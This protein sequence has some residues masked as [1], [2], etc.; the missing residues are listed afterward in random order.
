M[1]ETPDQQELP[2]EGQLSESDFVDLRHA[3]DLLGKPRL[4]ARISDFIGS[5][6]EVL[7]SRLPES[8]SRV[9]E[10]A[11]DKALNAALRLATLSLPQKRI[12]IRA[13]P[14]LHRV[15]SGITGATG[16]AFGL[17]GLSIE[18][19]LTTTLIMRSIAD[20]ARCEGERLQAPESQ[21]ACLEVFAFGGSSK[22][23]DGADAGY[24]AIRAAL[25]QSINETVQLIGKQGS[26]R[27]GAPLVARFLARI[28]S[29]FDT[30]VS[31]K[32]LAQ[33]IPIVGA[34]GGATINMLFMRH[35][36]DMARGHFV[37]R[38]LER[39]YGRELI[40][41]QVSLLRSE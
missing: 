28:A 41:H 20:I 39:L 3:M 37:V 4:I 30:V 6:I 31:E 15:L 32:V 36:Q 24:F 27:E 40:R 18:L 11:S 13:R 23:D 25:A 1:L 2:S 22:T 16:G 14:G 33:G 9:I 19:P 34:L 29:R 17:A 26:L 21:L 5:P 7:L 8:A 35:F 10:A 12:G 38:R